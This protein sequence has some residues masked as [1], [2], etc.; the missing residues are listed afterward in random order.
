MI[1]PNTPTAQPLTQPTTCRSGGYE[2]NNSCATCHT[3]PLMLGLIIFGCVQFQFCCSL[4]KASQVCRRIMNT[5]TVVDRSKNSYS[6]Y[7]LVIDIVPVLCLCREGR[8]PP[9]GF[10]NQMWLWLPGATMILSGVLK[11]S[12]EV[13]S[14]RS[15]STEPMHHT[16]HYITSCRSRGR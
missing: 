2:G 10:L 14:T 12:N 15:G 5:H 13:T 6:G 16:Y 4:S 8:S 1:S 9:G 7:Q 11:L 3:L